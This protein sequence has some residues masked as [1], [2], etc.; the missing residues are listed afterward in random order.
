[1]M[2]ILKI[3]DR[4]RSDK[5]VNDSLKEDKEFPFDAYIWIIQD[6]IEN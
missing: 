2:N 3:V 6:Y 1:M 4:Y 5:R